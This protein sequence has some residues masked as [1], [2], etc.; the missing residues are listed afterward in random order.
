MQYKVCKIIIMRRYRPKSKK[1]KYRC[2]MTTLTPAF[3]LVLSDKC[4]L[5]SIWKKIETIHIDKD[6]VWILTIII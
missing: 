5:V 6:S 2:F 1:D 4:V 3:L